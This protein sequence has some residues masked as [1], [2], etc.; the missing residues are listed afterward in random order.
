MSKWKLLNRIKTSSRIIKIGP[1]ALGIVGFVVYFIRAFQFAFTQRSILDE[2]VYL[3]KGYLF[4]EGIYTPFQDYGFWTQKAPLSYLIYG[5]VQQVFTPGLRTG[6]FFSILIGALAILGLFLV[7]RRIRGN[8]WAVASLWIVVFNSVTLRYFSAAMSQSLVACCLVW[9]LFLAL[10]RDRPGWQIHLGCLLSGI[11]VMTRQ[12]MAP[13]LVLLCLY[14]LWQHGWKKGLLYSLVGVLPLLIIHIIYWPD[15]LKMWTPWL[16]ESLTPFLDRWRLPLAEWMGTTTP[17]PG[18]RLQSLL[19]GIRFHYVAVIGGILALLVWSPRKYYENDSKYQEAVFIRLLFLVLLV[20]HL[21]A[22]LGNSAANNNNFFTV[23]PYL[24]F[25]D[26]LGIVALACVPPDSLKRLPI[27]QRVLVVLLFLAATVG[28]GY[29]NFEI[30]GDRLANLQLPRVN[31][32]FSTWRFL[33]GKAVLW[34]IL[35]NNYGLPYQAARLLL[36]TLVLALA[37]LFL[38]FFSLEVWLYSKRIFK[39]QPFIAILSS[40]FL[41]AGIIFTP[42]SVLSGGFREWNCGGNVIESYEKAGQYLADAIPP[43]S[44]VYWA[45]GNAVAVLTYVDNIR[46]FPAQVDGSWNYIDSGEADTLS[47]MGFWNSELANEWQAQADVILV[48]E[49]D[50]PSWK[51]YVNTD[52]F[53]EPP[54]Q[55]LVLNCEADSYL[56]VFIRDR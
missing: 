27:Y 43:D 9:M 2:G 40:V 33:P 1:L 34:E 32:F 6:R 10:G 55:E 35:E 5:W 3:L 8:W 31:D 50:Y 48:Q 16:P 39:H 24:A 12:N 44:L 28:V 56:R 54:R 30:M 15:I 36:P 23:N 4:T 13:A 14:L 18:A 47:R 20:F 53:N 11:M 26:F 52:N 41:I 7:I 25:F 17:E 45:G 37:G 22:G 49:K 51:E 42:T 21:W 46:L 38:I 19:E 29:G